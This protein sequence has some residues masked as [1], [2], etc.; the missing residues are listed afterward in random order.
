MAP[1]PP[2]PNGLPLVGHTVGLVRKQGE[3]IEQAVREHGPVVSLKMLGAGEFVVVADPDLVE[4]VC[5]GD[6]YTK[7]TIAQESLDDLLG[8]GLLLAT[9]DEWRRRR[10]MIQPVFDPD[11]LGTYAP[12]MVERASAFV[13]DL[14]P[15][16]TYDAGK[17]MR[18]LTFTILLDAV[19]GTDIDYDE[20]DLQEAAMDLMEPGKPRK[21]PLAYTVPMWVPIPM[22]LRYHEAIEEFEAVITTLLDSREP[23]EGKDFLSMLL[24]VRDEHGA[25]T[26]DQL[27]DELMTMLFAGHE[28]TATALTFTWQLLGTHP[29]VDRRLARELDAVLG[30]SEPTAADLPD[31]EYTEHV[32]REALRLYPPVPAL[33]RESTEETELGGYQI[34]A[35]RTVAPS[36]WVVHHDPGLYD[37]PWEFRPERWDETPLEER[38]RFAYFPFGGGP[39]RCIGEQF[40]MIEAKLIVATVAQ[41]YRLHAVDDSPLDPAV[42]IVTQPT[43]SIDV[44]P[45]PRADRGG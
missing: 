19:F 6:E 15:G 42:S 44:V 17:Q 26:D 45:E 40:A 43:R 9:G 14:E 41:Q 38:H 2:G 39:R 37:D 34:P 13:A 16:T 33:G 20:Y 7:A 29:D 32:V 25:L 31:L 23:G 1:T 27:R 12:A 18:R 30:S 35:G 10:D 24:T 21:Q 4:T 36:Q 8:E 22:W 11:R 28:T 3:Y 5:F